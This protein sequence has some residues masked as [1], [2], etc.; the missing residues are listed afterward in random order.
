MKNE[1][2]KK[3]EKKLLCFNCSLYTSKER[4]IERNHRNKIFKIL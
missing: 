4:K 1:K 2:M 3:K